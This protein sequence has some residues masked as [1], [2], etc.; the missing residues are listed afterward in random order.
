MVFRV[1]KLFN[2]K[3]W[4]KGPM[5]VGCSKAGLPEMAKQKQATKDQQNASIYENQ[6]ENT[7]LIFPNIQFAQ[8][9]QTTTK[10]Y[11]I[12]STQLRFAQKA[13]K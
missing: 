2:A 4:T 6:M 10:E 1:L 8:V 5:Q 13:T 11:E 9:Q 3:C 12:P 7:Q